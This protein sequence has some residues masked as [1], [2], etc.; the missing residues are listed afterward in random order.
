MESGVGRKPGVMEQRSAFRVRL[1]RVAYSALMVA[2][3]PVM[4]ARLLWRARAEPGY[5][6]DLPARLGWYRGEAAPVHLWVQPATKQVRHCCKLAMSKPGC[7]L[8][9]PAPYAASCAITGPP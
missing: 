1:M 3:Q 2:L 6:H 9:L 7:L 4:L 5:A 8:T